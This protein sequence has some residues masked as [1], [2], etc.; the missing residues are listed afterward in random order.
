VKTYVL[1]NA[2]VEKG[3]VVFKFPQYESIAAVSFQ[4]KKF[5]PEPMKLAAG[6]IYDRPI[7]FERE[8]TDKPEGAEKALKLVADP[9]WSEKKW[10]MFR[11]IVSDDLGKIARLM[12]LLF[13]T[14]IFVY[15]LQNKIKDLDET[16]DVASHELFDR[17]RKRYQQEILNI[18]N[19]PKSNMVYYVVY[20]NAVDLAKK[21]IVMTRQT[22]KCNPKSCRFK[23]GEAEW[24]DERTNPADIILYCN[25]NEMGWNIKLTSETKI[26]VASLSVLSTLRLLGK[27]VKSIEKKWNELTKDANEYNYISVFRDAIIELLG[28]AAEKFN[29][30]P[31]AFVDLLNTLISGKSGKHRYKTMMAPRNWASASIGE[32]GW[33]GNIQK[34]FQITD[35]FAQGSLKPK[36]DSD[37]YVEIPPGKSYVKIRYQRPKGSGGSR[38]GTSILLIPYIG[39]NLWNSKINVKVTNL[40][41][42]R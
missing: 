37:V 38:S 18:I 19:Q 32:P 28:K 15:L 20:N 27:N 41:S 7:I 42:N 14:E 25:G 40:T 16:G 33:S 36:P 24:T 34:D 29:G 4:S 13:E 9:N 21:M 31:K 5:Q 26:H 35:D 17:K 2:R 12:G 1:G 22:I 3:Y 39:D 30:D 6:V 11:S 23:G 8:G 10:D